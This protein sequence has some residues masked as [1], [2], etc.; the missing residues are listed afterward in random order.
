MP[1]FVTKFLMKSFF[2]NLQVKRM[3][4]NSVAFST[5]LK[6]SYTSTPPAER[7]NIKEST[8]IETI[9]F[10]RNSLSSEISFVR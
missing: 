5:L 2:Y 1:N 8:K 10:Y 4:A 6:E 9:N 7:V 3:F